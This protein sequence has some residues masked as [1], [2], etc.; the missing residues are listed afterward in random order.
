MLGV[1][2]FSTYDMFTEYRIK[3]NFFMLIDKSSGFVAASNRFTYLW[4]VLR[5]SY[6]FTVDIF[7]RENCSHR[8]NT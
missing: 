1:A 2:N 4:Q 7:A 3:T 8:I 5:N 6:R